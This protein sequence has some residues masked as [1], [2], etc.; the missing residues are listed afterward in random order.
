[1]VVKLCSSVVCFFLITFSHSNIPTKNMCLWKSSVAWWF[2]G[3]LIS[4]ATIILI[5]NASI[6]HF[7]NSPTKGW[8]FKQIMSCIAEFFHA[9]PFEK[10]WDFLILCTNAK[11]EANMIGSP[12]I[13][14]C[15]ASRWNYD[16]DINVKIILFR[17]DSHLLN[18]SKKVQPMSVCKDLVSGSFTVLVDKGSKY[19]PHLQRCYPSRF[20]SWQ[21]AVL[22]VYHVFSSHL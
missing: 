14:H 9:N 17:K 22:N 20:C 10:P 8:S 19:I 15:W 2:F 1:M 12:E 4:W 7:I 11:I 16:I 21:V 6:I 5:T 18:I 3:I 13:L